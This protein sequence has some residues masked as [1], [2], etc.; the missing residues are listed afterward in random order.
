MKLKVAQNVLKTGKSAKVSDSVSAAKHCVSGCGYTGATQTPR[1]DDLSDISK[2]IDGA[3]RSKESI[4]EKSRDRNF[5]TVAVAATE[6]VQ[7]APEPRGIPVFGTLLSFVFSGGPK[8]QHE[9]VDRRHKELGSIYRERL[10]PV[11]A[12][13]VNS[14]HEFRRIFRLEGSAPKHFLPEA[15]I[16]YNET[17]KCRR[18]LLFMYSNFKLLFPKK[19]KKKKVAVR[20]KVVR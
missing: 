8:R 11:T 17:R 4:V 3:N 15:W 7:E 20:L 14:T 2:S 18:G 16:L 5:A 9:Y 10:G 12:V 13:F 6:T 1:I 19:R